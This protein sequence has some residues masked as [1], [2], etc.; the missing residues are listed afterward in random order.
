MSDRKQCPVCMINFPIKSGG[1]RSIDKNGSCYRCYL[2]KEK[3]IKD[4]NAKPKHSHYHKDVSAYQTMDI[5]ALCKVW[6]AE[7]SGCTH[8]A[9]KKILH[10]GERGAKSKITDLQQAIESIEALIKLES[11]EGDK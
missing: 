5:Y 1:S 3:Y 9:L 2:D 6:N 10:A 7:P 4:D 11:M 8:H